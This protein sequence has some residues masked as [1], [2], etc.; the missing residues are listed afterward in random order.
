MVAEHGG[1]R[2]GAAAAAVKDQIVSAGLQGELD[3]ALDMVG[4][5]LEAH[6]N[7]AGDLAHAIGEV[8]EVRHAVQVLE[9][10][11]RDRGLALLEAAHLG[12]LA[13]HLVARQVAA[14]AGLGPLTA[15]EVEGLHLLEKA[16]FK[17][18]EEHTSE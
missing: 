15:L 1:G 5:E 7:A 6:G 10:G 9:G 2:P 4:A 17:R 11:R 18:S 13:R 12:D 8:A 3:V 14:G 16:L